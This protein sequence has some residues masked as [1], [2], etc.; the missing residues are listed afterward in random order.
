MTEEKVLLQATDVRQVYGKGSN[1][2]EALKGVSINLRNNESIGIIG[3]SGCGK[4]TLLRILAGLEAPLSGD[5]L[6]HGKKID[7]S[8]RESLRHYHSKVQMVFQSP[9]STFSPY[10]TIQT[11]LLESLRS[12]GG[13]EKDEREQAAALLAQV[14]LSGNFLDRLPHQLSGGQLQRVVIARALAL[15]PEVILL[16]EPTSA[17]DI[18]TQRS[19]LELLA[20]IAKERKMSLVFV[21][22]NSS[23]VRLLTHRIYVME[24]GRIIEEVPSETLLQDASEEYTRQ[25]FPEYVKNVV[26]NF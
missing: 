2:L 26:N 17:L 23:A 22:H 18:L 13:L 20:R 24:A 6:F 8:S 9:M 16:D 7:F 10:M 12:F 11:Y 5:V 19:I 21:G 14:E 25:F 4:S 3:L 1:R 15:N